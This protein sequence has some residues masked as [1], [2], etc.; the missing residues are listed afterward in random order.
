[1]MTVTPGI[2]VHGKSATLCRENE[3]YVRGRAPPIFA[4][5]RNNKRIDDWFSRVRGR[6]VFR[7]HTRGCCRLR[8][9]YSTLFFMVLRGGSEGSVIGVLFLAMDF[10]CRM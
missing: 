4:R 10:C 8:Y 3:I 7:I 5:A 2:Y 9:S 6:R 1:M